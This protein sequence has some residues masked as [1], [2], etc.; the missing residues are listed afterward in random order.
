[1]NTLVNA[2]SNSQNRTAR[3]ENGAV[4]LQS[5]LNANV[6]FFALAGAMRGK[7]MTYVWS[8]AFSEDAEVAARIALWARDVRGGAGE[9]QSFRDFLLWASVHQRKILTRILPKVPE[10][11]RWDDLLILIGTRFESN[12]AEL[13]EAALERRDG[14]CAKWMPRQGDVAAKLRK[15]L[16]YSPKGW[17]KLL[18]GL[19][20]VVEQQMCAGDWKNIEFSHVPSRAFSIYRNAFERHQPVRFPAFLDAAEK[21]EAKINA[22]AIFPHD[23]VYNVY[24]NKADRASIEQ[25]KQLPDYTA[26]S[27]ENVI[28]MADV[29]GSMGGMYRSAKGPEPMLVSVSLAL[30]TS[31]RLKGP[32]K[33]TFI[34]FSSHPTFQKVSG[35]LSDR[36]TQTRNANWQM[37]TNLQAAF[38]LILETAINNGVPQKDMPTKLLIVSDMEFNVATHGGQH[39]NFEAIRLKYEASG[40]S[41]PQIVFWNVKGRVGNMPAAY[42]ESGVAL[43]SGYSPSILKTLLAGEIKS[44]MQ[45]MLDTVMNSRYDF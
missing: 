11:G 17:R 20:N 28:V 32:F 18:V 12:I 6:D 31:E 35:N 25:W 2:L 22:G 21:G 16:G 37:S 24:T 33:D 23:I 42:N 40:Y 27:E 5:S 26:G 3:T 44:P 8:K 19:T 14:L 34:T 41:M 13:I 15:L 39:T 36:I 4:T 29:S 7:D 10:V 30:Y 45:I 1:M 43:V 9:R 38:E